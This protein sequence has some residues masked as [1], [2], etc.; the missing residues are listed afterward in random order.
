MRH[1]GTAFLAFAE[2]FFY[3]E[4]LSP[5]EMAK[6]RR[7]T[8]NARRDNRKSRDKLCVT[9][10]LD[11]LRRK[12]GRFQPKFLAHCTLNLWIDVRMRADCAADF[13]YANTL[14]R[15]GQALNCA[16]EFVIHQRQL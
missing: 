7:P 2:K 3:F 1:G 13:A 11:D 8:I 15:L 12:C 10:T 4:H 5:L 9:V 16:T 6:F 14:A